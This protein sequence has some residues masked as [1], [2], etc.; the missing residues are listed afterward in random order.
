MDGYPCP[1]Q[2][3]TGP[4][5]PGRQSSYGAVYSERGLGTGED[6]VRRGWLRRDRVAR[7]MLLDGKKRKAV[8]GFCL[9]RKN[10]R[11]ERPFGHLVCAQ[12]G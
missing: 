3:P 9:A 8:I 1:G 12:F 6:E 7:E 2:A 10:H 11:G 5:L 4:A